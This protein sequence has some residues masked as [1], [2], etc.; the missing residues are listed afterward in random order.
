MTSEL[1]DIGRRVVIVF[2][3]THPEAYGRRYTMGWQARNLRMTAL[4]MTA[5]T[6]EPGGRVL[7]IVGASHKPYFE[8]YLDQMHDVEI[9]STDTVFD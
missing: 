8:A 2:I 6:T 4:I 5:A 9:V 1:G 3:P 7:S